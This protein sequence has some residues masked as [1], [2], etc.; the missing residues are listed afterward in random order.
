MSARI[1]HLAGTIGKKCRTNESVNANSF[2][3]WRR[4][5]TIIWANCALYIIHRFT[6]M[7][8]PHALV[9]VFFV[10]LATTAP[11]QERI[12]GANYPLAQK[13][14]QD[15]VG[16]H[17]QVSTVAPQWIGKTDAFWY[18]SRTATGTRYWRVDPAKKEKV[19]LFDHVILAAALSEA[20]KKPLDADTL[21]LDRGVV[22][23]DGK[24]LTFV[25][26]TNQY[27]YDLTA[28]KL[29]PMG[30][31]SPAPGP[32]GAMTPE[33]IERLRATTRR[34]ARERDAPPTPR[35][36]HR[37]ERHGA[38]ERRHEE[39]R[40]RD[41]E[42]QQQ[43]RHAAQEGWRSRDRLQELLAR[44]KDLRLRLQVQPLSVRRGAAGRE[45]HA[46]VE[47]RSRRLYLRRRWSGR[48]RRRQGPRQSNGRR[49][50][51]GRPE[52]VA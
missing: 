9:A 26:S 4:K 35:R 27:E 36:R 29:K 18:A 15:F 10:A 11:A 49:N 14:N 47:G 33:T 13:F 34:R 2:F 6:A 52:D 39:R 46:T 21:R 45:G 23:A 38:E 44:Q 50:N 28:N 22:S 1:L 51:A 5:S 42:R 30:K 7:K 31:A 8:R 3:A 32:G 19:P 25:F 40:H 43:R 41:Q 48:L 20:S 24:K 37:A 16:Q 12:T 17:V